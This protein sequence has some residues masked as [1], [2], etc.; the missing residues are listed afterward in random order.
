[1]A[2]PTI[3]PVYQAINHR[4]FGGLQKPSILVNVGDGGSSRLSREIWNLTF[5]FTT[6]KRRCGSVCNSKNWA[7]V[8]SWMIFL[9]WVVHPSLYI[10]RP[11]KTHVVDVQKSAWNATHHYP[12]VFQNRVLV[13]HGWSDDVSKIKHWF[14]T[15]MKMRS[16]PRRLGG[17]P[18]ES[19]AISPLFI[20]WIKFKAQGTADSVDY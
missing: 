15:N 11:E 3:I 16:K 20:V 5:F 12:K 14:P 13:S 4:D 10:C 2:I 18:F 8:A 19:Y 9:D 6:E 17:H 1:M 7:M